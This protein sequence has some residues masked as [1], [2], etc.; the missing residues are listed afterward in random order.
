MI[1]LVSQLDWWICCY[2]F[3]SSSSEGTNGIPSV[4]LCPPPIFIMTEMDFWVNGAHGVVCLLRW[5]RV[6]APGGNSVRISTS[7]SFG[8]F[9]L[10]NLFYGNVILSLSL[11]FPLY[12]GRTNLGQGRRVGLDR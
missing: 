4:R 7:M 2:V 3:F 9:Q 10:A 6:E 5:A 11:N 8:F 1:V 12:H